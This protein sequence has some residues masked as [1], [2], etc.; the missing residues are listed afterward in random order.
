MFVYVFQLS[1]F[2]CLFVVIFAFVIEKDSIFLCCKYYRDLICHRSWTCI[3][4][5]KSCVFFSSFTGCSILLHKNCCN[6]FFVPNYYI[7]VVC[8]FCPSKNVRGKKNKV[9]HFIMYSELNKIVYLLPIY[10]EFNTQMAKM[11]FSLFWL[12]IF[13]L[14]LFVFVQ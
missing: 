8:G 13:V 9:N 3:E 2:F 11:Q 5:Q 1:I 12:E 7:I 6:I 14:S 10:N 4:C